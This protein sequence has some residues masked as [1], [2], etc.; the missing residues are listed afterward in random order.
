MELFVIFFL[1]FTEIEVKIKNAAF[2]SLCPM[3]SKLAI[4]IPKL[5]ATSKVLG[6]RNRPQSETC[7]VG[8]R[9]LLLVSCTSRTSCGGPS[10]SKYSNTEIRAGDSSYNNRRRQEKLM[11]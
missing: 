2:I 9:N 11:K 3:S 7:V 4:A 6:G 8:S 1:L 10:I 5:L